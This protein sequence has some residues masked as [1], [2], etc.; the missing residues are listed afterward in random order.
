L[1]VVFVD[2]DDF[3]QVNDTLGHDAGDALLRSFALRLEALAWQNTLIARLG[4]DEFAVL[5]EGIESQGEV[6][7]RAEAILAQ[8]R[9]PFVHA[10][11]I[12]DGHATIGA[13]LFP[14]HGDCPA[15]LLKS[16]DI[17]LYVAKA[18]GRGTATVFKASHRDELQQRLSMLSLARSAVREDRIVPFYQPKV[19][20]NEG[21]IYGFEALLRWNHPGAGM[22]LPA[23]ITAAFDDL[24]IAAAISDSIIDRVVLDMRSWLDRGLEFGHVAVN[25]AAAEFR[26][27]DFAERIL[28]RLEKHGIPPQHFQLEVT[29]TVFLG[30]GA[31][32]VDHALKLLSSAGVGIALDDFGTGYA[33]LRH[34]KQF[35]VDV[36]KIDQSF[37]R[38]MDSD[39]EDAAI[40]QAVLNLGRSLKIAVVA[41]GIETTEQERRLKAFGCRYGQGFLYSQAVP[42]RSVPG[43][44]RA[45]PKRNSAAPKA[46]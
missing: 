43:L 40:I 29:E 42:A 8:L 46:A 26:R 7:A 32:Y 33:S 24:D 28:E 44:L 20:L 41:E 17:A 18:E 4:G 16:A 23:T 39:P 35:P 10:G 3:K 2:L 37:V 34:L 38:D 22:Q 36:I 25:A 13:A 11:R 27:D 45:R 31:E 9:E 14:A 19:M 30:R 5:I 21:N 1:A 15:E 12:I 6:E